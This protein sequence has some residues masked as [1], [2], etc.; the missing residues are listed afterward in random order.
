MLIANNP[1]GST[2][3]YEIQRSDLWYFDVSSVLTHLQSLD[4]AYF[5]ANALKKSDLPTTDELIVMAS[6]AALPAQKIKPLT[7]LQGSIPR[8]FPGYFE[9]PDTVRVDFI[10]AVDRSLYTFLN[11]WRSLARAGIQGQS[12]EDVAP[13]L[14]VTDNPKFQFT[15][16][17][18]LL[19]GANKASF[20]DLTSSS[21][22]ALNNCWLKGYQPAELNRSGTASVYT[23]TAQLQC[24][25]I[26]LA[27]DVN[28]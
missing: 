7:V 23:V 21:S 17:A 12:G 5:S 26:I 13:L 27:F 16:Y 9:A 10:H 18:R 28:H 19:G 20:P 15:L 14:L 4:D 24:T 22:Y 2:S 3:D 1:W 8:Q 25:D 6:K 11:M